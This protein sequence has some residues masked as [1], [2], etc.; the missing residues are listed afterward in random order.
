MMTAFTALILWPG[1][2]EAK[3]NS[4]FHVT[5]YPC[6]LGL[7]KVFKLFLCFYLSG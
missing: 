2:I 1:Y 7:T 4:I 6:Q 5:V 3:N